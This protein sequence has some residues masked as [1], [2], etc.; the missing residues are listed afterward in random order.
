MMASPTAPD[1]VQ[2]AAEPLRRAKYSFGVG[3]RFARQ[4][5]AQLR[6][7]VLASA[8]GVHVVPVWNKSNREHAIVGSQPGDVRR[9]ADAAVRELGWAGAFHV[10]ADHI[11]L[12]TVEGFLGSSDY[13]TID[14]AAAI[15]KPAEPPKWGLSW[16][17]TLNSWGGS[18]SRTRSLPALARTASE[19]TPQIPL[20]R[21]GGGEDL[22]PHRG[23]EGKGR[24]ITEV[25]M[26]ETDARRRRRSC[27]SFWPRS[28]MK[29][30]PSRPSRRSS[31]AGST[32]VWT[33]SATGRSSQGEFHDDLAVIAH[34]VTQYG[35]PG[36]LKLSVHSGSDKFSLYRADPPGAAPSSTPACT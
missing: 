7:C 25:S 23:G 3:D 27:W 8:D 1:S 22:S 32:R 35:L 21:A 17:A 15:G 31:P 12:E 6:A 10:D 5:K 33:T 20:C 34:A 28:P 36:N 26:D 2:P 9:E 19:Q 13:Y 29:A 11:T 4:G 24:F 14:V 18:P 30:F 16:R